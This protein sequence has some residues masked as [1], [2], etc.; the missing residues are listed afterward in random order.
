[1]MALTDPKDTLAY[2]LS[3]PLTLHRDMS[4]V[5]CKEVAKQVAA[6]L[7]TDTAKDT[8]PEAEALWFYGMNHGMALIG[9]DKA[10]LEP[11]DPWE[12]AFVNDYH[13]ILG[14]KAVR[15]FYYLLIISI[16]EARHNKSLSADTAK[17][18]SQFGDVAG[19]FFGTVKGSEHDIHKAFL[20]S[21]PP[22]TIGQLVEC[23]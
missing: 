16:R 4:A 10:P 18:K 21:P 20:Q 14:P 11:L 7:N 13:A 2:H 5:S 17:M 22:T 23:I 15:A 19:G 12:L 1:M 3:R 8:K 6:F 9:A